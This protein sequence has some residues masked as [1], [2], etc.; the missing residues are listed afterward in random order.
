MAGVAV[1]AEPAF[2][3]ACR[4]W[5]DRNAQHALHHERIDVRQADNKAASSACSATTTCNTSNNDMQ[6]KLQ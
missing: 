4:T 2:N 3:A 6:N 1:P 5:L